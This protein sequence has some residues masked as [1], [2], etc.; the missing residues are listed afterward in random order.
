VIFM[1]KYTFWDKMEPT[2]HTGEA[3]LNHQA[4]PAL[5]VWPAWLVWTALPRVATP[6]PWLVLGLMHLLSHRH[7]LDERDRPRKHRF[8]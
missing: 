5:Q 4:R 1:G 2:C 8:D 3:R 6:A 7:N